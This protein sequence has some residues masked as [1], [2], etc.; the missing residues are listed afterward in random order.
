[1]ILVYSIRFLFVDLVTQRGF[2]T[3]HFLLCTRPYHYWLAKQSPAL[4][5]MNLSH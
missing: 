5:A 1:M 3:L 4:L 2:V